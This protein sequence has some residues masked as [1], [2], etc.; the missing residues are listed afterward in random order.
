MSATDRIK[1][2]VLGDSG[3]GKSSLVHL[4]CHNQ[5]IAN[6]S[7]TIGCTIDV[8][9]HE[10]K[11][12]TPAQNAEKIEL[13]D[14]GG[15]RGH[16][17]ARNVFFNGF[18]GI[19]LV[20]DLTNIKSEQNL[21][22]WLGHVFNS[23]EPTVKENTSIN[24]SVLSAALFPVNTE[25]DYDF[26]MESFFERNIPV[27]IVATKSDLTVPA[28]Q[29]CSQTTYSLAEECGAEQIQIN[30][31]QTRSLA[32]GSTNAVL[33]SRFFDKVCERRLNNHHSVANYLGRNKRQS[34]L[35]HKSYHID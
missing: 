29:R 20:H 12:G 16:S 26:D 6:P 9:L 31:H 35:G 10:Y 27:L 3:V 22:K 32:P 15:S 4:I 24:T 7:W 5:A 25:D 23:R 18:H 1:V 34:Y 14:I 30:C 8:K 21:R 33:L 17:S 19:I 11:E 28:A 2:L 13:W